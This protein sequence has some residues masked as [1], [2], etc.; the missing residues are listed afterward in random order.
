MSDTITTEDV[1]S[2]ALM[3]KED[4]PK[5]LV[6]LLVAV[7]REDDARRAYRN[8]RCESYPS[9]T[10]EELMRLK[11]AY[12]DASSGVQ[13]VLPAAEPYLPQRGGR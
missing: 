12:A 1:K 6:D 13:K 2:G 10:P 8:A 7:V 3:K 4:V 11:E 9:V 5:P